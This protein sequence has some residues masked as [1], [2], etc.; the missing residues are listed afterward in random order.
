M[1]DITDLTAKNDIKDLEKDLEETTREVHIRV[2]KRNGRKCTTTLENLDVLGDGDLFWKKT[3]EHF[4]KTF[5]CNGNLNEKDK[6][7][8]LSGGQRDNIKEYLVK[9]NLVAEEYI[10]T[11]GF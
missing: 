1:T 2:R 10:K 4:K 3:L 8:Q 9:E 5:C 6:S 11:H 7:L